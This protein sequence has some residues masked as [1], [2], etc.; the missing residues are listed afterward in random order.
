MWH[1]IIRITARKPIN[2]DTLA[3]FQLNAKYIQV[4][5]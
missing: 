1:G 5:K 4:M 3:S 2:A